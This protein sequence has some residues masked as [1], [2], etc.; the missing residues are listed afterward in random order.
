M[1]QFNYENKFFEYNQKTVPSKVGESEIYRFGDSF[2]NSNINDQTRYNRMYNKVGAIYENSLLGKFQF[3]AEDFRYNYYYNKIL[4]FETGVIPNS[5]ND[6]INTVGGQ[7]EYRKNKW[8]GIFQLSNS[9]S[10]QPM[11]NFDAKLKY[12]LDEKNEFVFQ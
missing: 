7:Y 6:V 4:I 9:I 3:F 2:V 12:Q 5:I 11:S 10:N 8:N 1:H